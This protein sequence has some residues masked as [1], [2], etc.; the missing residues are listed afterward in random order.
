[1]KKYV[2]ELHAHSTCSDGWLQPERIPG[3][4]K[5]KGLDIVAVTDHNI[6]EGGFRAKKA[7]RNGDPYV[8]PGIEVSVPGAHILG[9]FVTQ[10][11]RSKNL[12]DA[13][14]E[15]KNQNGI[16]VLAHPVHY[17]FFGTLRGRQPVMPKAE[18]L[19]LFD[20]IEVYNSRNSKKGNLRI[21]ELCE[22]HGNFSYTA[23]SDAHFP[24]E[25]GFAKTL[26]ELENLSEEGIKEAFRL[27]QVSVAE[28]LRSCRICYFVTGILNKIKGKTY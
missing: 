20:A 7:C 23:G 9:Y 14:K 4:A 11:I 24:F 2:A 18:E 12:I 22:E 26:F 6:V 5:S 28:S 8:I 16:A 10:N 3:F 19:A 21:L 1:M 13:V 15:I 17:P 25:F 27:G